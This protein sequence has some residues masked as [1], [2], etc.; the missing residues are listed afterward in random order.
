MVSPIDEGDNTIPTEE[1]YLELQELRSIA[2]ER[3]ESAE[4]PGTPPT[5]QGTNEYDSIRD[6]IQRLRS[7]LRDRGALDDS[8]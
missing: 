7:L 2:E 4:P 6:R 8:S 1:I 3:H 5:S